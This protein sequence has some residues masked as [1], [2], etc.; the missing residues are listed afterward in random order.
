ML[1]AAAST[2]A[3][4]R[5][6]VHTLRTW[7]LQRSVQNVRLLLPI[8]RQRHVKAAEEEAMLQLFQLERNSPGRPPK[9]TFAELF[10]GWCTE[11]DIRHKGAEVGLT[12]KSLNRVINDFRQ[13]AVNLLLLQSQSGETEDT[14]DKDASSVKPLEE[15]VRFQRSSQS[16]LHTELDVAWVTFLQNYVPKDQVG[17]FNTLCE[18]SDLRF[19]R[20]WHPLARSMRRRIVMHVGPTNSGKTY[21]ALQKFYNADQAI[22]C[23]PLRLLA[24]EIFERANQ[25]SI[26]CN[27]VTGEER[28]IVAPEA[29]RLSCTIEMADLGRRFDIAVLDE[30]QMISDPQRGWAW[31]QALLGLQ[32]KELHLCGEASAIPVVRRICESLSE[33]L[34]INEYE[35]LS[36]LH[37]EPKSLMSN[38]TNVRKGDCVIAF[39]RQDVFAYK[40]DIERQTGMKC[41]VVYGALP[42]ET[43]SEQARLFNDPDSNYDILVATD[44]V[45][46]GLNLSIK[47]VVFTTLSKYDGSAKK[48]LSVS[49]VKQIGG[50]AGRYSTAA[51][52]QGLVTCLHERDMKGLAWAMSKSNPDIRSAGLQPTLDMIETFAAQLPGERMSGLL[53]KFEALARVDG[54]L[55]SLCNLDDQKKMADMIENLTL[56]VRERYLFILAPVNI[57]DPLSADVY[58][59]IARRFAQNKSTPLMNLLSQ[60]R[61]MKTALHPL[62]NV[63]GTLV[64]GKVFRK[65]TTSV[66][67]ANLEAIHRVVMTYL[68]LR[69]RFHTHRSFIQVTDEEAA[70]IKSECEEL[71]DNALRRVSE[72]QTGSHGRKRVLLEPLKSVETTVEA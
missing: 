54:E 60:N 30:I 6:L 5:A 64:R 46:M 63:N 16:K 14:Q 39:S 49:A 11:S 25:Q 29:G 8:C 58:R 1:L 33:E 53:G 70:I 48:P 18:I 51:A 26:L 41:A 72:V 2:T 65:A 35:R 4:R 43:R 45:G 10:D 3:T 40:R 21:T 22:Y 12:G 69:Q 24:H 56:T 50:R 37:I 68:W 9:L 52:S 38:L 57:R 20:E 66:E 61:I 17:M 28:K 67:L 15:S 42:P 13:H 44:A 47:R 27:M 7:H 71:I 31:T 34:V 32:A 62:C 36:P 23:G 19:P 59:T 55:Y